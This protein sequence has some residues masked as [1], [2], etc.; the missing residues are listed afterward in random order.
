MTEDD[1]GEHEIVRAIVIP[2]LDD[3]GLIVQPDDE[4]GGGTER[5]SQIIGR[6]LRRGAA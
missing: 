6:P 5:V 1:T 4:E 3:D 2:E